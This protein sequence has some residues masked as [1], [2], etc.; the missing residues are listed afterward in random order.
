[1]YINAYDVLYTNKDNTKS[2][3]RSTQ[4][5]VESYDR[6]FYVKFCLNYKPRTVSIDCIQY[7]PKCTLS[8]YFVT[9]KDETL[10]KYLAAALQLVRAE[11][12]DFHTVE[13]RDELTL[14]IST[15][16]MHH[17]YQ[18]LS[19]YTAALNK[20]ESWFE[21]YFKATPIHPQDT[22]GNREKLFKQKPKI[23]DLIVNSLHVEYDWMSFMKKYQSVCN[24]SA[25]LRDFIKTFTAANDYDTLS[26]WY[27]A[28]AR[29]HYHTPYQ[30]T[31]ALPQ[32]TEKY[33]KIAE[34]STTHSLIDPL[35]ADVMYYA[36]DTLVGTDYQ[37]VVKNE[38]LST[39]WFSM[40]DVEDD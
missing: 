8:E 1:M 28:Y 20:G 7:A 33:Y 19:F 10:Y 21:H 29:Q 38:G 23:D 34:I 40:G 31:F 9:Q 26:Y 37:I 30:L 27:P 5:Y 17:A 25:T 24:S 15:L 2:S 36:S 16:S 12:P 6:D 13:T 32:L 4:I 18:Y 39:M 14:Q 11:F 35:S 3:F 22:L